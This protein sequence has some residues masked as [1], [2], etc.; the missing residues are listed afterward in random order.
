MAVPTPGISFLLEIPIAPKGSIS[1]KTRGL[2]QPFTF[3]VLTQVSAAHISP[4]MPGRTF[5]G[6][7]R[8]ILAV[9]ILASALAGGRAE[10]GRRAFLFAYDSEIVPEGDVELE[11]WWW[12]ESRIPASAD[13]LVARPAWYWIWWAPVIGLTNH[14]EL[15]LPFQIIATGS[16]TA[17]QTF[18]AE[19]YYRFFSREKDAGFQ[20]LVRVSYH[21]AISSRFGPST[22]EVNLVLAYGKPSELH[23]VVNAGAT[24]SLPWPENLPR[25][26]TGSFG[27]GLS[28]PLVP[29]GEFRLSA[30]VLAEVQ[31]SSIPSSPSMPSAFPRYFAGGAFSWTRGRIWIT[32]GTMVGL[33]GLSSASAPF[34]PRLLWAVAL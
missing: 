10:A 27:G 25:P 24:F 22:V 4:A 15:A 34:V 26:V 32:A 9:L 1:R 12:A 29:G 33:T 2:P 16:N 23:L 3:S 14:L 31:S 21:H 17:L 7:L 13:R 20:P 5:G 28:V 6:Q 18:S 8:S 30:E 11:Q 19:A